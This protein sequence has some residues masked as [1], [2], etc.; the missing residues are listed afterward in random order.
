MI[1]VMWPDHATI[2][3]FVVRHEQRL[4]DLFGQ[5]LGL[6]AEAGLVRSG[7]VAIDGTKMVGNASA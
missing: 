1:T 7:V 3:R 2:A 4:A 5:V 6:C